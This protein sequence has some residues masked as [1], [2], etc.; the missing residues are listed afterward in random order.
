MLSCSVSGMKFFADKWRMIET[1]AEAQ[2]ASAAARKKWRSRGV[3]AAWQIKLVSAS[4]GLLSFS[5]FQA[6]SKPAA[7]SAEDAA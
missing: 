1:L 4:S 6:L 7:I 5:D 2:G 3:P